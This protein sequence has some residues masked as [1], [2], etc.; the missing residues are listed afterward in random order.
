[1]DYPITVVV[2]FVMQMK[3]LWILW[4]SSDVQLL[5]YLWIMWHSGS[6]FI[7]IVVLA[8]YM[9]LWFNVQNY[10]GICGLYG[11][12]VYCVSRLNC[13]FSVYFYMVVNP[14]VLPF[15][16]RVLVLFLYF[17]LKKQFLCFH[18]ISGFRSFAC[19]VNILYI[20]I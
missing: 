5:W 8:G 7:T 15:Y 17:L 9:A 4:P 10:C 2:I 16:I 1:M 13:S 6:M 20:F 19:G 3:L 12:L 18:N 14:S 11:T